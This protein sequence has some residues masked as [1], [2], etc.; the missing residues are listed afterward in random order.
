MTVELKIRF[1]VDDAVLSVLH[2]RA[3]SPDS[4]DTDVVTR[5]WASRLVR[6]SLTWVGAFSSGRLV[7]FVHAV[8]DGGTHAFILDTMVHPDFRRLGIGRDLVRAVTSKAFRAGCDWVHVDYEPWYASFYESECGF[9]PTPA[10]LR[11]A[12]EAPRVTK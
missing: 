1:P 11:S 3:F 12:S 9:R 2:R 7:G 10:G 4:P 8:W 5:P 6:H